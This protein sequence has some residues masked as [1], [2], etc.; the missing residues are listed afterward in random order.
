MNNTSM[1]TI[2]YFEHSDG[3]LTA[4]LFILITVVSAVIIPITRP[5]A[6]D[7]LAIAAEELVQ[8]TRQVL[9]HTHSVLIHQF[10]T[11]ITLTLSL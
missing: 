3:T 9:G 4:V 11:V 5:H 1:Q 2:V 10:H 8:F 6:R 7:A